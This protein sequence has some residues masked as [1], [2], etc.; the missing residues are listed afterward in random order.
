MWFEAR[1][2]SQEQIDEI[3]LEYERKFPGGINDIC[4]M[5]KDE[6][7]DH[8]RKFGVH[9]DRLMVIVRL[10]THFERRI[11]SLGYN[12]VDVP[13]HVFM[14]EFYNL[15]HDFTMRMRDICDEQGKDFGDS[16]LN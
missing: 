12:I 4:V 13:G 16:A 7:E 6:T 8:E 3:V 1:Y 5:F 10:S 14:S 11:H 15:G 2:Y 9:F